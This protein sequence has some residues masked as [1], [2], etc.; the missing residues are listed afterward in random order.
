[1]HPRNISQGAAAS[2][3]L[4]SPLAHA[5]A[6]APLFYALG[7]NKLGC[8]SV[9]QVQRIGLRFAPAQVWPP[10]C[11]QL[12]QHALPVRELFAQRRDYRAPAARRALRFAAF[13]ACAAAQRQTLP[14]QLHPEYN[15]G[16]TLCVAF[17]LCD[18]TARKRDS[19]ATSLP[20]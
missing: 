8:I 2:C 7:P 4:A 6:P 13:H 20:R 15:D 17:L 5:P 19:S 18:T 16:Q 11:C 9:E 14:R 12:A 10:R 1:M 3:A